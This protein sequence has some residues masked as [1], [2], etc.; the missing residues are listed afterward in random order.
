MQRSPD[1]SRYS[2]D[3]LT[4]VLLIFDTISAIN[5]LQWTASI[6]SARV[7]HDTVWSASH[8]WRGCIWMHLNV[9]GATAAMVGF[10]FKKPR[11]LW[12]K[13]EIDEIDEMTHH[14][15]ASLK[16]QPQSLHVKPPRAFAW[17]PVVAEWLHLYVPW[18]WFPWTLTSRVQAIPIKTS[19]LTA[20]QNPPCITSMSVG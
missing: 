14:G 8:C 15:P 10:D 5:S 20:S 4:R 12:G 3:I 9:G 17:I 7:D 19:N 13:D 11:G 16:R 6:I 18:P 2:H 1:I